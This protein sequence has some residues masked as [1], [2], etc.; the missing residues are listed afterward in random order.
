MKKAK[1]HA[2]IQA[3]SPSNAGEQSE[4]SAQ[5]SNKVGRFRLLLSL[6]LPIE[7]EPAFDVIG[8]LSWAA[9]HLLPHAKPVDNA[10]GY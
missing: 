8:R 2:M 9:R 6:R 5:E 4:N 7:G 10:G 1:I 3:G